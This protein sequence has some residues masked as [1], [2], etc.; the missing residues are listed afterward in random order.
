MLLFPFR[1][2]ILS[3]KLSNAFSTNSH[4]II[5]SIQSA[6]NSHQHETVLTLFTSITETPN[7]T[8]YNIVL[9]S[10][11]H[12]NNNTQALQLASE[13]H[14]QGVTYTSETYV[15]IMKAHIALG[16]LKQA[17]EAL[18]SM[19]PLLH[20]P[21]DVVHFQSA[22]GML[23]EAW[24]SD[25]EQIKIWHQRIKEEKSLEEDTWIGALTM[26]LNRM[27]G[28][29]GAIEYLKESGTVP[30]QS[31]L[32]ILNGLK[33]ENDVEV[34]LWIWKEMKEF[35]DISE[36]QMKG[37]IYSQMMHVFLRAN[38]IKSALAFWKS[39]VEGK[40]ESVIV[41]EKLL[42]S[43]LTLYARQGEET[44]ALDILKETATT[45]REDQIISNQ[46]FLA[47]ISLAQNFPHAM[48]LLSTFNTIPI[49]SP[50]IQIMNE[51]LKKAS[52]AQEITTWLVTVGK[53]HVFC[54]LRT[55]TLLISLSLKWND[56]KRVIEIITLMH[57][58]AITVSGNLVLQI[59]EGL[60]ASDVVKKIPNN[61]IR[62]SREKFISQR[63]VKED[64]IPA[65]Y[66]LLNKW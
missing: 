15:P 3:S 12:L 33:G 63:V 27:L 49:F 39:E 56:V 32:S 13:I 58:N 47:L 30:F 5:K 29:R 22:W 54:N 28:A 34:A 40:V 51:I 45:I 48:Q 6:F 11:T 2:K 8:T 24:E 42:P 44:K 52:S 66:T 57:K 65:L 62:L 10:H 50:D 9:H 55:Y 46:P 17:E 23:L 37:V 1:S 43:L 59:V 31:Y 7:I 38:D 61:L 64:L 21:Q 35:E 20:A 18:A 16:S 14:Q 60:E 41:W 36:S 53:A 19:L 25:L 26:Q 4:Q